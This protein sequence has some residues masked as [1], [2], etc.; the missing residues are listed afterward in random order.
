LKWSDRRMVRAIGV[1]KL[2]KAALLLGVGLAALRLVHTD[3]A[4]I[5]EAWVPHVGLEPGGRYVGRLL[6]EAAKLTPTK[7]KD[8]GV[9]SLIYAALFLT[10]GIGLWML[11]RWAEWLTIVITSSLVP[12]EVWE[13]FRR[14]K[15]AKVLVLVINLALVGYLIWQLRQGEIDSGKGAGS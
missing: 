6:V 10:E 5:L 13:I 2:A 8:V 7:I 1:F 15:A 14:P 11:K 9:G 12:V 3:I 4:A